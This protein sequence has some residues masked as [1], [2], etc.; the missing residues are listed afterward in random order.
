MKQVKIGSLNIKFQYIRFQRIFWMHE[1]KKIKTI[2]TVPT[3]ILRYIP[4]ISHCQQQ[5]Y[6][7][8]QCKLSSV[9]THT[10]KTQLGIFDL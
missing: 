7:Q 1:L 10:A 5:S 3:Y 4:E 2:K 8:G 6:L 9:N